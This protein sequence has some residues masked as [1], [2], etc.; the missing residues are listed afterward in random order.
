M[1]VPPI[2]EIIIREPHHLLPTIEDLFDMKRTMDTALHHLLVQEIHLL[3]IQ[4]ITIEIGSSLIK[5]PI[6]VSGTKFIFIGSGARYFLFLDGY[7][8]QSAYFAL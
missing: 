7:P 2:V 8:Q 3:V 1:K 5:T 4:I 6:F